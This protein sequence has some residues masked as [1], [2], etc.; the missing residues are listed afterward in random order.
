MSD[1]F[2]IEKLS[3]I[4]KIY[5]RYINQKSVCEKTSLAFIPFVDALSK[6]VFHTQQ[7]LSNY[8]GFNKAHTSRTLI[9]MKLKGL[10][11][12]RQDQT[13]CLTEKGK[14]FAEESLSKK[15]D[16]LGKLF[17]DVSSDDINVFKK[18]VNQVINNSQSLVE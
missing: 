16:I 4:R 6:K 10:I 12:N 1:E 8:L 9:K 18:V 5:E 17:K 3:Q 15:H 7:E 14:Q 13:I 2:E 11:H